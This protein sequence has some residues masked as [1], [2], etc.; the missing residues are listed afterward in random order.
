MPKT[1]DKQKA[2]PKTADK[3]QS[4]PSIYR[5][6]A[7]DEVDDA[8]DRIVDEKARPKPRT[9]E[10]HRQGQVASVHLTEPPFIGALQNDGVPLSGSGPTWCAW[11][12]T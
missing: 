2:K 8:M 9:R 7:A 3:K 10:A 1:G 11:F 4:E 5:G 6:P 12:G